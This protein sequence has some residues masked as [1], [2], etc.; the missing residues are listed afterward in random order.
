MANGVLNHE[1]RAFRPF[2]K[3]LFLGR[4][5]R[6]GIWKFGL[7]PVSAARQRQPAQ[8]LVTKAE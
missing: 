2:L 4:L 8:P 1:K 6:P 3:T 5:G 7:A